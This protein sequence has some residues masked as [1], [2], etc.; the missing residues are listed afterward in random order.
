VNCS[1]IIVTRAGDRGE[2]LVRALA[3]AGEEALWLPAFEFG[4]APDEARVIDR[5][6][7]LS[8]Y[9]LAVFVSPAAVEA[10]A[11]RIA[12]PWPTGT[13][14]GAVGEGTRRAILLRIPGAAEATICAPTEFD[15]DAESSGS[16]A[17]WRTLQTVVGQM[18]RVLIL[19]AEHGRE[20][21]AG[22]LIAA[23]V[24]VETLAVY[25]RRTAAVPAEVAQRLRTWQAAGR[26][27]VL[28][29]ASSEAVEAVVG[30]LD[31]IV[32]AAWSRDALALASHERIAQRLR[33]AGFA[34][35][36][37]ATLDAEAIR[38]A[39]LTQ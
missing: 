24:E 20:W 37:I 28:V 6:G 10:V 25:T 15:S 7:N 22:Q 27:P 3:D 16:E 14:I 18:R 5:L 9:Q 4:P 39:A 13:A 31:P 34:R 2:I 23:G 17:L 21:L 19:R 26:T 8:S 33:A 30:L 38:K 12:R 29:L 1:P 11:P 36:R 32:G 35:V